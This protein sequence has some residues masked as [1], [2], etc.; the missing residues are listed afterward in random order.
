MDSN[1]ARHQARKSENR[2]DPS[3]SWSRSQ[4]TE[5]GMCNDVLYVAGIRSA[6]VCVYMNILLWFDC[7][8]SKVHIYTYTVNVCVDA[9][10]IIAIV[11]VEKHPSSFL[12]T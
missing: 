11:K 1:N 8:C 3:G 5:Q 2:E 7:L 6:C 12:V 10:C 9:K 4:C